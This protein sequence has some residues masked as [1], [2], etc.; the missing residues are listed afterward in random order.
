[1]SSDAAVKGRRIEGGGNAIMAE[2][3]VLVLAAG[4]STRMGSPKALLDWHGVPLVDHILRVAREAGCTRAVVVVGRDADAIQARAALYDARVV[5]N[6]DPD[7]GQ[8]S[9]LQAGMAVAEGAVLCW[10]VDVPLAGVADVTALMAALQADGDGICVPVFEGVRGHPMLV[11]AGMVGEFLALPPGATARTVLE[12][13]PD[14]VR[15]VPVMNPGVLAD[16]DTPEEYAR[17]LRAGPV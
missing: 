5:R 17:A 7:R 13:H 6:P 2:F 12:Q 3:T 1:M 10:P 15:E 9:S 4:D 14:A 11:G 8:I 16:I